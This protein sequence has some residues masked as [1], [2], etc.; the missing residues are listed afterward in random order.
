MPLIRPH[1]AAA[2][3]VALL[4]APALA[5][6]SGVPVRVDSGPLSDLSDSVGS[7]SRPVHEP[8]RG[9]LRD[10]S[11]D[12]L[13]DG[14]VS[15]TVTGTVGNGSVHDGTA[16]SVHD[17]GRM[18]FFFVAPQYSDD[19]AALAEP[20]PDLR[21]LQDSVAGVEPLP[22]EEPT[23]DARVDEGDGDADASPPAATDTTTP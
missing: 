13:S 1:V 2:A 14:P 22:V 9:S 16:G 20:A 11:N 8:G 17:Q 10:L 21:N 3:L 15:D 7:G 19:D 23:P 12:S 18:P 4:V 5:Q 6:V